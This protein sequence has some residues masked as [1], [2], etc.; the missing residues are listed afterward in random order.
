M[1]N[2]LK[3]I[4]RKSGQGEALHPD[5]ATQQE[6]TREFWSVRHNNSLMVVEIL[7]EFSGLSG[8]KVMRNVLTQD[9]FYNNQ[10]TLFLHKLDNNEIDNMISKVRNGS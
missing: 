2:S 10:Y 1:D 6:D 4:L 3:G 8:L 5:G 9:I 7:V